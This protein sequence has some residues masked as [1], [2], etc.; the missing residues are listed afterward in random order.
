[1]WLQEKEQVRTL[2]IIVIIIELATTAAAAAAAR[3]S[4]INIYIEIGP[5]HF[6][7]F[8]ASLSVPNP[9]YK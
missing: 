7:A 2:S 4:E 3:P 9:I 8:V 6:R 5:A 1:M